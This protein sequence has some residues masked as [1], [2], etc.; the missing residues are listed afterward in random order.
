VATRRLSAEARRAQLLDVAR[1]VF[2]AD[3]YHGAAMEQIAG[4]AGVTKPVLY[5]HFESKK[6]LYLALLEEDMGRLLSMVEDTI[7]G[8]KSNRERIQRATSAYFDFIEEN[9]GSFRL[10]FRETMGA[11]PDFREVVEHFRDQVSSRIGTIIAAETMLPKPESELLARSVIG[12][13]EA[14][15]HWWLDGRAVDKEKLVRDLSELA[16]R[17]LAGFPRQHVGG[18]E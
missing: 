3:G 11:D 10:L 2:A 6:E 16:W 9:E 1:S 5:Q 13:S 15:A 12:M 14:A 4:S 8:A 7:A 18:S 17:G